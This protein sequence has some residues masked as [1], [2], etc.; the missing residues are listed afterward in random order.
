VSNWLDHVLCPVAGQLDNVLSL[1]GGENSPP[2]V[3][4]ANVP[5]VDTSIAGTPRKREVM[6]AHHWIITVLVILAVLFGL[7]YFWPSASATA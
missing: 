1:T 6:K 7:W 3:E 4:G 5:G 2:V